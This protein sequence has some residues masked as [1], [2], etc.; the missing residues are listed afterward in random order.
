MRSIVRTTSPATGS[1]LKARV[2]MR[3]ATASATSMVSSNLARLTSGAGH[4]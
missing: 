3:R 1:G 2:E 4:R